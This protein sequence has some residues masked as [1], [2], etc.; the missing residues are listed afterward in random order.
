[1]TC[2]LPVQENA[3]AVLERVDGLLIPGGGDFVPREP[4]PVQIRFDPVPDEQLTFDR[5]LLETARARGLPV[6]GICYGMQLIAQLHGGTFHYDLD[7]DVPGALAH[8]S[9]QRDAAHAI[10]LEKPSGLAAIVGLSE[11]TVNSHHHQAV[12]EPG[13]GMRIAARAPDGVIEAIEAREGGFCLGVQWHPERSDS[14]AD[15]ALLQ[16]FVAACKTR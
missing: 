14:P 5:A 8:R 16:A 4:Y 2:Y 10:A 3:R 7:H 15:R 13:R 6:L 11:I 9:P 12:A 1:M